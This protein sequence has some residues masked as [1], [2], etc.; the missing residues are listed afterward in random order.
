M[1]AMYEIWKIGYTRGFKSADFNGIYDQHVSFL[2]MEPCAEN[3]APSWLRVQRHE[4]RVY[5]EPLAR[6]FL[7]A[8]ASDVMRKHG[9][10]EAEVGA[11]Q[12]RLAC[13]RIATIVSCGDG[14]TSTLTDGEAGT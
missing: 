8:V 1:A 2:E 3:P 5:A 12:I 7:K 6:G 4:S 11:A 14:C 13:H 10:S 9:Y